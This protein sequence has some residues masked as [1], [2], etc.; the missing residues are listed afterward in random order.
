MIG[1]VL[2]VKFSLP[3]KPVDIQQPL[4]QQVNRV[5][6]MRSESP[7]LSIKPTIQMRS[8]KPQNVVFP[9]TLTNSY[10]KGGFTPSN[11]FASQKSN[12]FSRQEVTYPSDSTIPLT[13]EKLGDSKMNN[14]KF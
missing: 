2:V 5:V 1:Q 13:N 8:F 7:K 4:Q 3:N 12:F 10:S 9:T 14:S 6:M 11:L